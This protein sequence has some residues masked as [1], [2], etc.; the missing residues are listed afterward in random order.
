MA[1][2]PIAPVLVLGSTDPAELALTASQAFFE[3]APVV[4]LADVDDQVAQ[5]A[6][7]AAALPPRAGPAH[8]RSHRGQRARQG[9]RP[10]RRGR[11]RRR[12]AG[13]DPRPR[14]RDRRELPLQT[15]SWSPRSTTW[16]RRPGR[17]RPPSIPL[18]RRSCSTRAR[19]CPP[20]T[21][22]RR[23]T[24]R[25]SRTSRRIS[26]DGVPRLLTEVLALVDERPEHVAAVATAQAAESS[27]SPCPAVTHGRRA[28]RSRPWPGPRRWPWSGSES[29]SGRPTS[30]RRA[31][32]LPRRA[33]SWSGWA[34]RDGGQALRRPAGDQGA[35]HRGEDR[36]R[37][38]EGSGPC[39]ALR[40]RARASGATDPTVTVPTLELVVTESSSS[41][42][43]DDNYS[44][45]LAA[46][47]VRPAV[48]AS[49]AAGQHVLLEFRPGDRRS[50][51][52]S[53]SMP[54]CWRFPTS[55]SRSTSTRG[56][57][58]ARSSRAAWSLP[59]RST[60]SWT[61]SRTSRC[62]R[63]CR[64]RCSCCTRRATS[65]SRD[66]GPH[67]DRGRGRGRGALRRLRLRG[68]ARAGVGLDRRGGSGALW[69]GWTD[70][71]GDAAAGRDVTTKD[72]SPAP[73]LV[74]VE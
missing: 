34:A 8:G 25:T 48:E 46:N 47:T 27:R 37:R 1:V 31:Y 56:A 15:S 52:R 38:R 13:P 50:S 66:R 24:S 62:P 42:G 58:A 74:V 71:V 19:S 5:E 68:H 17:S 67:G 64:R 70:L 73:L 20:R 59:R 23:S 43:K 2:D 29:P 10:P 69:W 63:P 41:A 22:V 12:D 72:L 33:S 26:R 44:T 9:G 61:T 11:R 3:S 60:R 6:A 16:K 7:A 32:G 45:E 28:P 14:P 39:G 54:T 55:G 65:R 53:R 57:R 35:D 40:R 30:S 4:I 18:S 21:A 36:R 51:S 49:L